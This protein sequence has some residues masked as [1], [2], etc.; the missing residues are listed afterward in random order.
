MVALARGDSPP[1][2]ETIHALSS[3]S[4]SGVHGHD[5]VEAVLH[6][7]KEKSTIVN[8]DVE[9]TLECVVDKHAGFDVDVVILRVPICLEGNRHAVP[10]LRVRMPQAITYCLDDTLGQHVRL[11]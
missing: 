9:F 8:V 2:Q 3:D 1:C 6:G 7:L 5:E 4:D 10:P 11:S